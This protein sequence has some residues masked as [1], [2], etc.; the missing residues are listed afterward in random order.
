MELFDTHT[1][2]ADARFDADRAA[3]LERARAA[4][5]RA[6]VVVSET[7]QEVQRVLAV[8]DQHAEL[9]PAAGLY[10]THV[11]PDQAEGMEQAIRQ[12]RHRLVAIGEVGLD[13]WAV[14]Q[15]AERE[16][17]REIFSRFIDLSLE[18]DLPLNVHSR[19]AGRQAI[20]LLVERGARKVQM[21]AFD[22]RAAKALPGV[23][24]A[25]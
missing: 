3:V 18:L 1:H 14:K 9:H 23:S 19:S 20:E 7:L 5:V 11:D 25:A 13:R 4:G 12:Y 6:V 2:L 8:C 17:Q 21:H 16:I 10:P 15:E 24:L 22:G